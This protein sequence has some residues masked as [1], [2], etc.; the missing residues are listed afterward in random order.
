[1][2]V[3]KDGKAGSHSVRVVFSFSF[4]EDSKADFIPGGRDDRHRDGCDG[5]L[6]R[7]E[8]LFSIPRLA[9]PGSLGHQDEDAG[10]VG[11]ILEADG[12]GGCRGHH[13][14]GGASARFTIPLKMGGEHAGGSPASGSSEVGGR[15]TQEK[16]LL[17]G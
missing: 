11:P 13:A 10:A 9:C 16:Q 1:M 12:L 6:P 7:G 17:A 3:I 2:G 14:R 15:E 8:R 4:C 5:A